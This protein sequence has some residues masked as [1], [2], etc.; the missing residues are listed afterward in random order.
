MATLNE[1]GSD[2][3]RLSVIIIPVRMEPCEKLVNRRACHL[4]VD[5]DDRRPVFGDTPDIS[6]LHL[7]T[8]GLG[9]GTPKPGCLKLVSVVDFPV[10]Q[11]RAVWPH[12]MHGS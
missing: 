12:I 2:R 8:I 9:I 10:F 7:L 11:R 3:C 4:H 1:A 5:A 6:S